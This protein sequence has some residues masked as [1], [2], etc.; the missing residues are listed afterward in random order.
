[1]LEF[2]YSGLHFFQKMYCGDEVSAIVGDIGFSNARF[3][4]AGEDLPK[5][6]FPGEVF[7]H[8]VLFQPA[9]FPSLVY[10]GARVPLGGAYRC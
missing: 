5:A 10:V 6:I 1:M 3:G 2:G 7:T 4:F 9:Y 8:V